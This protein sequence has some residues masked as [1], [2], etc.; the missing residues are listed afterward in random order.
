MTQ[1]QISYLS[2][3]FFHHFLI[4]MLYNQLAQHSMS[5]ESEKSFISLC[6]ERKTFIVAFF[7]QYKIVKLIFIVWFCNFRLHVICMS[8]THIMHQYYQPF[9]FLTYLR[10]LIFDFEIIFKQILIINSSFSMNSKVKKK[11]TSSNRHESM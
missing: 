6:N 9:H 7:F 1:L 11:E 10:N 5:Y 8:F 2:L 4:H 3:E